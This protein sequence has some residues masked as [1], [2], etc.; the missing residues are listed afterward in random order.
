MIIIKNQYGED[1]AYELLDRFRAKRREYFILLPAGSDSS[2]VAI[3]RSGGFA[4][5]EEIFDAVI[6]ERELESVYRKFKRRNR[7]RFDFL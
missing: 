7:N 1:T 5:G 6:E 3:F 4:D 2:L